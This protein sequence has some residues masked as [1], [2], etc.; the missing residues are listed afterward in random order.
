MSTDY[1]TV[2]VTASSETEAR[3]V[4][5]SLFEQAL[6]ACVNLVPI[7]SLYV[8]EGEIKDEAEVLMIIK[9]TTSAFQDQIIEVVKATHSYQV[10][11]IIGLPI[12]MGSTDYLQW[13]SAVVKK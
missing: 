3:Q 8:W 12:V 7:R 11:E 13:I 5:K 6:V 1:L 4:A 10:P 9:T 2:L